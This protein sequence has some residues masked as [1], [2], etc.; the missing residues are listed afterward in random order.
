[1][2]KP[3]KTYFAKLGKRGGQKTRDSHAPSYYRD[4]AKKRW[5]NVD[6]TQKAA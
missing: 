5:A 2:K 1:M 6:K 3:K 4:L